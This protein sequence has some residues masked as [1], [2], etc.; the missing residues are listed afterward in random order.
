MKK[1]L[2]IVLAVFMLVALLTGCGKNAD[3]SGTTVT[4]IL[5]RQHKQGTQQQQKQQRQRQHRLQ[6]IRRQK[7]LIRYKVLKA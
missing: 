7:S 4:A 2:S 1:M 6:P 5:H 3:S